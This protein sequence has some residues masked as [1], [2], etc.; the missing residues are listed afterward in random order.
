MSRGFSN[1]IRF[2]FGTGGSALISLLTIPLITWYF[3]PS[4]FGK[5]SMFIIAY[6]L[7]INFF[8]FAND[9]GFNRFYVDTE[10]DRIT[11]LLS[12][13][14]LPSIIFSLVGCILILFFDQKISI[15]L[16]EIHNPYLIKLLLISVILG[17]L[18]K[19]T[20]ANLRMK[21]KSLQYSAILIITSL[22]N[23]A[24]IFLLTR[25]GFN[26]YVSIIESFV[27]SLVFTTTFSIIFDL[28]T[29]INLIK[30]YSFDRKLSKKILFY[31]LPFIPTFLLDWCFQ[32]IDRAF[33]RKYSDFEAIGVY[34]AATK[35]S[36]ALNIVQ[37]SFAL[38]WVP[39]SYGIFANERENTYIFSRVFNYIVLCF[40]IIISLI[41]LFKDIII[42]ILSSDYQEVGHV[43]PILLFIPFFY[44]L[45]EITVVGINFLRRTIYHLYIISISLIVNTVVCFYLVPSL[46]AA[47]AAIGMFFG[48]AIFFAARTYFGFKFYRFDINFKRFLIAMVFL[49]VPIFLAIFVDTRWS[50]SSLI[51][52]LAVIIIYELEVKELIG[53]LK[54]YDFD[55]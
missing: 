10:K 25:L 19:F 39:Y 24:A 2:S 29:W 11:S 3:S 16:F 32:S 34:S 22:S 17:V 14:I 4:D 44:C 31:S 8:S 50:Y 5:S 13:S 38:F 1:F 46:G 33:L 47:G 40:S 9:Q 26:T 20:L 49:L 48:Y 7:F 12:S 42:N 36:S 18:N 41:L 43:F 54:K 45:S 28:S 23:A 27:L 21:S 52:I 6:N 55:N 15:Y 51:S 30:D 35:I 37:A 53:Y